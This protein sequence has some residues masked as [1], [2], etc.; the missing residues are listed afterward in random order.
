MDGCRLGYPRRTLVRTVFR[1]QASGNG[2]LNT[3]P[4]TAWAVLTVL[5]TGIRHVAAYF[6]WAL[7]PSP[8]RGQLVRSKKLSLFLQYLP[9]APSIAPTNV[10][11]GLVLSSPYQQRSLC[12]TL[13]ASRTL[14]IRYLV[15]AT[16]QKGGIA[17]I[18]SR[19][20]FLYSRVDV[21]LAL[22]GSS[23]LNLMSP[24]VPSA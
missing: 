16:F 8:L 1:C 10:G 14:H 17:R 19:F 21:D 4:C 3:D 11:L 23:L 2:D 6:A 15:T 5:K 22:L 24:P 13:D 18:R 9:F 12:K 7:V 20:S